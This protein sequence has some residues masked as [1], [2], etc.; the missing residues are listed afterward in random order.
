[1]F[2]IIVAL[3]VFVCWLLVARFFFLVFFLC[4]LNYVFMSFFSHSSLLVYQNVYCLF[5]LRTTKRSEKKTNNN[6]HR[7]GIQKKFCVGS[8]GRDIFIKECC[9]VTSSLISFVHRFWLNRCLVRIVRQ[10]LALP[11]SCVHFSSALMHMRAITIPSNMHILRC[12]LGAAVVL[13]TNWW[14]FF[15]SL[16]L[17]LSLLVAGSRSVCENSQV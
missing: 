1:M 8:F 5:P 7:N 10:A 14:P 4:V 16:S 17:P 11:R 3:C 9:A 12:I 6:N 13:F 15:D 2:S